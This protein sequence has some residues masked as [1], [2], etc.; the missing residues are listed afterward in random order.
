MMDERKPNVPE[1]LDALFE[2]LA[3]AQA[4]AAWQFLHWLLTRSG[5]GGFADPLVADVTRQVAAAIEPLTRG[6]PVAWSASD[7]V[8]SA[9]KSALIAAADAADYTWTGEGFPESAAKSAAE[10]VERVWSAARATVRSPGDVAWIAFAAVEAAA[11]SAGDDADAAESAMA[12]KLIKMLAWTR[13]P[14]VAS[15]PVP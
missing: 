2:G 10:S 4:S 14:D 8:D 7:A 3:P 12:D 13:W 5:I 15:P 1:L 6:Q 9:V 11:E